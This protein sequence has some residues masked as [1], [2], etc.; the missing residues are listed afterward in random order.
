M[1]NLAPRFT[2]SIAPR[3][4]L[5]SFNR[6]VFG[7]KIKGAWLSTNQFYANQA[8]RAAAKVRRRNIRRKM[9][10]AH[11]NLNQSMQKV[12]SNLNSLHNQRRNAG[13]RGNTNSVRLINVEIARLK[14]IVGRLNKSHATYMGLVR[15][16]QH[17][18]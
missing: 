5:A 12:A 13:A 2:S 7:H 18:L 3:K 4:V 6:N 1:V 17:L 8:Q 16:Y 10:L 11:K 15:H 9:A 14:N